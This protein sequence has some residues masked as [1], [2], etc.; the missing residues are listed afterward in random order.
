M[1][2]LELEVF[3]FRDSWFVGLN[4]LDG[5]GVNSALPCDSISIASELRHLLLLMGRAIRSQS[6]ARNCWLKTL[7]LRSFCTVFAR[8]VSVCSRRP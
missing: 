7:H 2:A 3:L 8:S 5:P 4:F 1:F 6:L